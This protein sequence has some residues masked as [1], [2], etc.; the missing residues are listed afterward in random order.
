MGQL[1]GERLDPQVFRETDLVA[2]EPS[3][4]PE[5]VATNLF[6][7]PGAVDA[8]VADRGEERRLQCECEDVED[9]ALGRKPLDCRDDAPPRSPGSRA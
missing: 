3:R 8:V 7:V 2:R 1:G 5:A 9:S 4:A 6:R